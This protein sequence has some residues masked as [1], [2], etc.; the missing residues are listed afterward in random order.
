MEL[1]NTPCG[2][3]VESFYVKAGGTYLPLCFKGI[4]AES[5]YH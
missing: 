4:V 1:I 2:Q 3:N 5:Q